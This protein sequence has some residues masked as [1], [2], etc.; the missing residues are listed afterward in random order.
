[1]VCSKGSLLSIVGAFIFFYT[2][3]E[4]VISIRKITIYNGTTA[5]FNANTLYH[6]KHTFEESPSILI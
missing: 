4:P 1:M 5:E 6:L 3:V 2:L